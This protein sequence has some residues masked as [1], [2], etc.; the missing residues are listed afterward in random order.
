MII[1]KIAFRNIFRQK[2]RSILTALSM[3]G[4]FFLSAFFIGFSDGS[5]NNIIRMF[6]GNNMGHIQIHA[7]SYLEKPSL[8]KTINNYEKVLKDLSGIKGIKSFAPRLYTAGIVSVEEKSSG[9][10]INGI[11]QEKEI[12]TT[13]FDKKIIKG[14]VFS[15][16]EAGEVIIGEGLAKILKA[17][18]GQ[19][20]VIVS[21]GADGSIANDAYTI[22]GISKSGNDIEDR[23]TI[24]L[25]L[26][27]AQELFVLE[28]RVHEIAVTIGNLNYVQNIN[29]LI[30]EKLDSEEI[31]AVPWQIFAKSFYDAMKADEAGMWVM[32]L[33]IMF[34][35]A[36]GVLNTV[37][38]SVL[39][40]RREYGVLK[41]MGT[42]PMDIIK[43]ILIEINILAVICII[44]G[45]IAGYGINLY[46]SKNGIAIP[47]PI[48][49]GGMKFQYMTSEINLRSFLIPA[50]T[51]FLSATIVGFF[52]A[53]KASKTDPA[54]SMRTH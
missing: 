33:I 47:E 18:I 8:Y 28:G 46:L 15:G 22:K 50:F 53:L 16:D 24:Y 9:V 17:G 11:D 49:Y 29:D 54:K 31:E 12:R 3:F 19:E 48:T 36:I 25:P 52:P 51:V 38:M 26:K 43:L 20:L 39:E 42:K 45:S 13:N 4:G 35:V 40:R 7:A 41:A 14:N 5:Y 27:V 34:V 32:L 10:R 23:I 1:L 44:L 30:T 37:L 2:R 21:Q 6:T